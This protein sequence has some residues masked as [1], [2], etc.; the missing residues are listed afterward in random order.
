MLATTQDKTSPR[1]LSKDIIGTTVVVRRVFR[2][3]KPFRWEIYKAEMAEPV[4]V[5]AVGFSNMEAAY[6]AGQAMLAQMLLAQR[7]APRMPEQ[8]HWHGCQIDGVATVL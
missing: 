7:P 4:H 2:G 8:D 5:S 6:T 3:A 1:R